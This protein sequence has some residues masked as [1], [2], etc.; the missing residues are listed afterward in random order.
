MKNLSEHFWQPGHQNASGTCMEDKAAKEHGQKG[1]RPNHTVI[2]PV[3]HTKKINP[4]TAPVQNVLRTGQKGAVGHQPAK[5]TKEVIA[6]SQ[7]G[8]GPESPAEEK[9]FLMHIG[10]HGL[11]QKPFQHTFSALHLCS[12]LAVQQTVH[13]ACKVYLLFFQIQPG[14]ME[15]FTFHSKYSCLGYQ[16][17]F[18][19]V[20]RIHIL[21]PCD[22]PCISVCKLDFMNCFSLFFFQNRLP[23]Y[24]SS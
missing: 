23:P 3:N 16:T 5:N 12:A 14:H 24:T 9:Q 22:T 21:H 8:S 10:A 11:S 17:D 1:I 2:F 13:P 19:F 6:C 4:G 7:A 15:V 18:L 20:K